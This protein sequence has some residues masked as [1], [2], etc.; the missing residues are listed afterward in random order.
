MIPSISLN[1]NLRSETSFIEH[2]VS[3]L[4]KESCFQAQF[5]HK[6]FGGKEG[7]DSAK[8]CLR[9]DRLSNTKSLT[10]VIREKISDFSF[11]DSELIKEDPLMGLLALMINENPLE[12]NLRDVAAERYLS[13]HP[14]DTRFEK[15]YAYLRSPHILIAHLLIVSEEWQCSNPTNCS[16][17]DEQLAG[18]FQGT[19]A[20]DKGDRITQEELI[21]IQAFEGENQFPIFNCLEQ[22]GSDYLVKDWCSTPVMCPNTGLDDLFIKSRREYQKRIVNEYLQDLKE[23]SKKL[24]I[25]YNIPSDQTAVVAVIGPY[26]SGKSHFTQQRFLGEK[27][28]SFG[29]DE[30]NGRLS[31]SGRKQDHH[32][33]A[34]MLHRHLVS[35][36]SSIPV[37]YTE[38]AATDEYRFNRLVSDFASRDRIIIQEIANKG[39]TSMDQFVSREGPIDLSRLGAAQ[40]SANDAQRFRAQRIKSCE[41]NPKISYTLYCNQKQ[42]FIRVATIEDGDFRINGGY[43]NLYFQLCPPPENLTSG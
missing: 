23:T 21:K 34:M 35:E 24:S 3:S 20:F 26:G 14:E 19:V 4:S 37:L 17:Y 38:T 40:A 13:T 6:L 39:S 29:L 2:R 43:E 9:E 33:E 10:Q 27:I 18:L 16:F 42:G 22:Q 15:A 1:I 41:K 8:S 7:I 30:I 36:I 25:S 12:D 28:T 31:L 5:L 11:L 32:F